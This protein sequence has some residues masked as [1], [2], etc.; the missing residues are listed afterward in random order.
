MEDAPNGHVIKPPHTWG[1]ASVAP[2]IVET[3]QVALY[4]GAP[5]SRVLTLNHLSNSN[6]K[7]LRS[8]T[9]IDDESFRSSERLITA[10]WRYMRCVYRL[11]GG[12]AADILVH[13]PVSFFSWLCD[14]LQLS[15]ESRRI[16]SSFRRLSS[17][18]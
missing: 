3:Y 14:I 9:A 16:V 1:E 11:A 10:I 2:E 8:D 13:F 5:F 15:F 17:G 18:T 7:L 12:T 4:H 6:R